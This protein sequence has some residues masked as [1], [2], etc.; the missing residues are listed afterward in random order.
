MGEWTGGLGWHMH[1][2]VYG[3]LGNRVLLYS[4]ENSTQYPV[5]IYAGKECER[6]RMCVQLS[7]FVVQQK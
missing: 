5:I 6:A 4:T 1:T 2:E 7:H 3:M